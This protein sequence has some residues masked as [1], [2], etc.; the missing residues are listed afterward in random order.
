[1]GLAPRLVDFQ[2]LSQ[3]GGLAEIL[4][5]SLI[6]SRYMVI[7]RHLSGSISL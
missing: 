7:G 6:V 5:I 4:L 1:M 2:T 3:N